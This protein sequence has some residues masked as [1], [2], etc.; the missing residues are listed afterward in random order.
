MR[1]LHRSWS[2]LVLGPFAL[3]GLAG[4][5][6][7]GEPRDEG[8]SVAAVGSRPP[9][10]PT[11]PVS[12]AACGAMCADLHSDARNCGA[13]GHA[14]A[15][16]SACRAGACACASNAAC[17]PSDYCALP[18]GTCIGVGTCAPRPLDTELCQLETPGACGCDGVAYRDEC[19]PGAAGVNIAHTGR[20]P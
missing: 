3:A 10:H 7:S 2:R 6:C 16:G 15:P 20:C 5:A 11:C 1:P 19:A 8:E 4:L 18:V 12:Q 17:S 9:P 14:C 13:C